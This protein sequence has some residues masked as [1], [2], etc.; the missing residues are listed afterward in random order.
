MIRNPVAHLRRWIRYTERELASL[1][2]VAGYRRQQPPVVRFLLIVLLAL[3]CMA[4]GAAFGMLAPARVTPFALPAALLGGLILWSLPAGEYAPTRLI[5]P[6]FLAFFA[7]LLL[8]P[9]YLAVTIGNL[10][11]MTFLRI[12]GVPLLVTF[13]A[14]VSISKSFRARMQEILSADPWMTRLVISLVALWSGSILLS[15]DIGQSLNVYT[16]N[17]LNQIGIFFVSCYVFSRPGFAA[18][19][20]KMLMAC[21][22]LLGVYAMWEHRLQILPWVGHVPSFLTVQDPIV[23]RIMRPTFNTIDGNYRAKASATTPLGLSEL[24]GLTM[25]FGLHYAIGHFPLATRIAAVLYVPFAVYIILLT[26]SR[27]GFVAACA[28][29]MFYLL[30]WALLRWRQDKGSLFAPA[31]IM[32]YP[33]L[34]AAFV[35]ATFL[36]D[37]L[38]YK[39]W[40]RGSQANST[41]GRLDQWGMGIPKILVNPIGHGIGRGGEA[42]GF[43]NAA[44]EITIDSYWLGVL[45]EIGVVGFIVYFGLMLRGAY[46]AANT[47]VNKGQRGEFN[48][49]LPMAVSLINFVIVKSAFTQDNNHPLIFMMLGAVIAMT[50]RATLTPETPP[51]LQDSIRRA[52]SRRAVRSHAS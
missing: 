18:V 52:A 3:A 45:L 30:I 46:T 11:W 15:S 19:W 44:G 33:A 39:F 42:L 8:W 38:K 9:N 31:L 1:P 43:T 13:L 22:V 21:L 16:L 25:P 35:A 47:V 10:P 40:G 6:L 20:G 23:E 24:L 41:Q 14:C 2:V 12:T 32:T 48:L 5:E 28:S 37:R 17:M 51:P 36:V 26:D 34:F 27:L 7:A 29:V 49:L 4:Y 50:W